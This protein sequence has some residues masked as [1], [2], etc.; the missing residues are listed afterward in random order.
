MRSQRGW[1]RRACGE[2]DGDAKVVRQA[3]LTH[4]GPHTEAER[5]GQRREKGSLHMRS[6]VTLLLAE[7]RSGV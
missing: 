1:S 5:V 2:D 7:A 4:L 3:P 6:Y